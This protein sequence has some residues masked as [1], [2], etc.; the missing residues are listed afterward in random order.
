MDA[1]ELFKRAVAQTDPC[2]RQVD[3]A[4]LAN[5]TPCSEWDLRTLV[6]HIIYELLWVPDIVAGK[7]IA[8]VG[9]RY[10]GDVLGS[11]IRAAWDRASHAALAAVESASLNKKA[12]LSYGDVTVKD[13]I[14]EVAG[15]VLIHGWDV[16]QSM[17]YTMIMDPE[18][19]HTV[20][21]NFLPK[22]DKLYKSGLYDKPVEVA[23]D[24]SIQAKLLGLVGR[25]A[26]QLHDNS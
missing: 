19:A 17:H 7:T 2:I 3:D 24:A 6:R 10:E 26:G 25:K 15:D 11:D 8:E 1:V 4:Q 12:H 22:K 9:D 13:Y 23:E 16:D 20:Y 21:D 5:S 14:N 18:L